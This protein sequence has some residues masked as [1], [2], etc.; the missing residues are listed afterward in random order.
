MKALLN[1]ACRPKTITPLMLAT[2]TQ[3]RDVAS[4]VIFIL[5]NVDELAFPELHRCLHLNSQHHKPSH[6][7]SHF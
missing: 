3:A 4:H 2:L 7:P 1:G 5:C 6:K